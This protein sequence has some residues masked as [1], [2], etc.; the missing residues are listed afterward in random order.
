MFKKIFMF[1]VLLL[2]VIIMT[3]SCTEGHN[4]D[5]IETSTSD[6]PETSTIAETKE[7]LTEPST[8]EDTVTEETDNSVNDPSG[9][10]VNPYDLDELMQPIFLGNEVKNET[11]MFLEKGD[12]VTLLFPIDKIISVTS[13]DNTVLYEEGKD[14]VIVDGNIKVTEN[15]SIPCVTNAVYNSA[16]FKPVATPKTMT[17]FQVNVHYTHSSGWEGFM[18]TCEIDIYRSF[19]QKLQAGENVTVLFYGDSISACADSSYQHGYAPYQYAYPIMFVQ[20]LADLFGYTV[21]YAVSD[22]VKTA[23]NPEDYVAGQRGV[24]TFVNNSVGG[25]TSKVAVDNL[26]THIVDT[27][28]RFGCDLFVVGFGMNDNGVN[29]STNTQT[30]IESV[31]ALNPQANVVILSTMVPNPDGRYGQ[32]Q[33]RGETRLQQVAKRFRDEGVACGVCCMTSTSLAVLERK[34]FKDY[35]GNNINHPNDFFGRVYAQTLLQ[36]IIGYENMN[37]EKTGPT[38]SD[39][40]GVTFIDVNIL[41]FNP[42]LLAKYQGKNDKVGDV[43]YEAAAYSTWD[44]TGK[45]VNIAQDEEVDHLRWQAWFTMVEDEN[46]LG[47]FCYQI[48]DKP[49]VFP[50]LENYGRC[51]EYDQQAI[52]QGGKWAVSANIF[53]SLSDLTGENTIRIFYE[54]AEGLRVCIESFTVNIVK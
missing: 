1:S 17:D 32:Y 29:T 23:K 42:I 8:T 37:W 30:L 34:E 12:V 38:E 5:I 25:W 7:L 54:N 52:N 27:V 24:I 20:S 48:N 36:T 10:D 39:A 40:S 21:N 49:I 53:I 33:Q 15:S 41:K 50:Y 11:V 13:Y 31:L 43:Y 51:E 19:I 18:Q 16:T 47:R 14:Y 28:E 3:I 35:S 6:S 46:S 45:T 9:L 44:F 26:Q 2:G 4:S 22:A